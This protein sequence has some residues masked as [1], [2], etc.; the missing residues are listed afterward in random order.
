MGQ[1]HFLIISLPLQGHINPALQFA[2]RLIR[3]GAHVTFAVS[4]S[5]H[6]RMPKGPTLPGLTLVPFSDGYDDGIKLEDHAQHYLSEIKR[7]GSETLRRITA[8]NA[9]QGRPVTC[10]V[11]TMLLAWAAELARSLQLPSALLWI[12]SATVFIIF[13]HYFDGYGDVVGNCS[14][15]GSDPIELPG[16]PMLLSS[17]DIPSFLLSSNIYASWIPAFQEDMEALRQETNPKVLVNTF[18]ALEAEALRAVDKVKLIGIGPLVPSAFLDANDPSDSSFGGDIFQDP[19][20]CIDW[21]NSKPKSS[22]V[23]VSFG[24]LCVVSKQQM[25]EI[26]HA[27]LHSGRPFLWVIRSA[28]EN[29]EVE[30]EKLSCRKELEEKGMIVVWCPQLDVLS[31]PSLGCFITHCGWN[32]TLECLASGVPVVAFPQWTDQGTN[33]KL[34]EDVWKT[35]VRVTANE[36]GIVEGEEI[37]RCLEVVMGG[38]ERGEELRRNAGK[39][40][41][42][43]REAVKDGGSSDCNLKAFLDELGQGSMI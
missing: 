5:A 22:V 17:R 3:T 10:L 7:C 11:H 28:S 37:K 24:T 20:N 8:I 19:S 16:L 35:G 43:A 25:E 6:R 13:H 36:E 26:A 4:V 18:D 30:E 31:H 40:K 9:D 15:E 29:G 1:H 23:Y 14:N 32:S 27:L 12:Q 42:L 2:K 34:I 33:G 38:G 41:D 39:W 21:L